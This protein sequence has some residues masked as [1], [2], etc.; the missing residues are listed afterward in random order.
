VT[1]KWGSGGILRWAPAA[2]AKSPPILSK[3]LGRFRGLLLALVCSAE[4]AGMTTGGG[5]GRRGQVLAS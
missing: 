1:E 3:T 4:A 5:E 2:T